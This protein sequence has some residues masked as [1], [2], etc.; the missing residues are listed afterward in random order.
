[1]DSLF[2]FIENIAYC[3]GADIVISCDHRYALHPL[4]DIAITPNSPSYSSAKF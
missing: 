1:M 4:Q 3:P 2:P